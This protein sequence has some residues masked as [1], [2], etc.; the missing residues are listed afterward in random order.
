MAGAITSGV[1]KTEKKPTDFASPL[2]EKKMPL[3]KQS[4]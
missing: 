3:R 1:N 2:I 4:S